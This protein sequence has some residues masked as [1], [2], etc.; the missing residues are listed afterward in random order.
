M[1]RIASLLVLVALT[2]SLPGRADEQHEVSQELAELN[3][4]LVLLVRA[5][6]ISQKLMLDQMDLRGLLGDRERLDA[7]IRE[8]S[9]ANFSEADLLEMEKLSPERAQH[10]RT[11]R[12]R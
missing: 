12:V 5:E 9:R 1:R 8:A 6:V 2:I 10:E 11:V 7:E 4:I 3:R